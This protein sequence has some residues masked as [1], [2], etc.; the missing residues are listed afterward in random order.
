ML[1][2]G[3]QL[4]AHQT[5]TIISHRGYPHVNYPQNMDSTL[6]IQVYDIL[7]V[8]FEIL[9]FSLDARLSDTCDDYLQVN[10]KTKYCAKDLTAGTT[11]KLYLVGG[12]LLLRFYS[13]GSTVDTGFMFTYD[14]SGKYNWLQTKGKLAQG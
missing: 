2:G 10:N 13:D 9:D 1:D 8:N 3:D 4:I 14:F 7:L 12:D 11:V 5:G 6:R